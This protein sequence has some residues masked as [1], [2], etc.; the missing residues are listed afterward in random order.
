MLLSFQRK[1]KHMLTSNQQTFRC[2]LKLFVTTCAHN[3]HRTNNR[4]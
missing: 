1:H 3:K 2:I 4:V